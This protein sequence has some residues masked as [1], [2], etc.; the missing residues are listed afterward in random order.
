[1]TTG[2]FL[3]SYSKSC[4]G[5]EAAALLGI[6]LPDIALRKGLLGGKSPWVKCQNPRL[7]SRPS[8]HLVGGADKVL[9]C[10]I[11]LTAPFH[12]DALLETPAG[13]VSL[14]SIFLRRLLNE[15][16]LYCKPNT[17]CYVL[18]LA[19][20]WVDSSTN[21]HSLPTPFLPYKMLQVCTSGHWRDQQNSRR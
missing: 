6:L 9:C 14:G 3:S 5:R 11:L 15:Q 20:S 7:S 8:H 10:S 2:S 17:G 12:G 21:I 1:M 19:L 4:N 16:E 13:P 18:I